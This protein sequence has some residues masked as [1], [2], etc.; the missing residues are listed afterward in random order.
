MRCTVR[1][2]NGLLLAGMLWTLPLSAQADASE[3]TPT[4]FVPPL[5]ACTVPPRSYEEVTALLATP[6]A[7]VTP[8]RTLGP[9]PEGMP[10]SPDV[11]AAIAETVQEL[12]A[13][14]NAGEP[15]RVY[16]LYTDAF[17][18]R[19]LMRQGALPRQA[20]DALATPQPA[21]PDAGT[22]ILAISGTRLLDD[23]RAGAMVTLQ[24]PSIPVP[25]TFFF[26]FAR[27]G[28]RWLIDDVLDEITF[29]VP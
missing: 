22:A 10:A 8:A 4:P 5:S 12:V 3:V 18:Q 25:K 1:L 21:P 24:F 26:T 19:L 14:Y 28:S 16:R 17:L 23:G 11:A 20:Y 13:C 27:Q 6:V 15:L 2:G 29:S 7:G 9:V